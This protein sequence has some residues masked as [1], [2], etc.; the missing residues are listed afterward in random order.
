MDAQV[1]LDIIRDEMVTGTHEELILLENVLKTLLSEIE[2]LKER[3][4]IHRV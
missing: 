3:E 4:R 2:I 1:L